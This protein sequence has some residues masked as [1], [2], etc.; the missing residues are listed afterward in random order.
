MSAEKDEPMI[1][2]KLFLHFQRKFSP[3]TRAEVTRHGSFM[4][5]Q[6]DA[7]CKWSYFYRAYVYSYNVALKMKGFC[8][9]LL[10]IKY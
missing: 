7:C 5:G 10:S 2:A 6:W 8:L 4:I 9:I 3:L 1:E